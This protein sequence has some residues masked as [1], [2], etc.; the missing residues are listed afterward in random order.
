MLRRVTG[1]PPE[2]EPATR[3]TTERPLADRRV[4][5]TP[6]VSRYL[7]IG[8]RRS[9]RRDGETE[10]VYVDRPGPWAVTAFALVTGLSVLD[11][12][13]TLDLLSRGGKEANPVML[14][15]LSLGNGPFV[16][17][18]TG[19]TVLGAGFLSLHK[20]WP[21]GRVCLW[22]AVGFYAALTAWH[23]IGPRMLGI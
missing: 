14:A 16:F 22:I 12:F 2:N 18:K 11:A 5:P 17:L 7:F 19:V 20:N 1:A 10:R 13:L 23:L 6:M 21:L 4:S 15:A 9:G 3:P 8:R